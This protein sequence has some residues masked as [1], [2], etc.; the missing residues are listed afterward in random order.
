MATLRIQARIYGK[1]N[2]YENAS[3]TVRTV[4]KLKRYRTEKTI[5]FNIYKTGEEIE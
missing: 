2:T 1:E 4:I 3:S 5:F